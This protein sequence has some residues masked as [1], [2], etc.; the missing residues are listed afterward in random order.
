MAI[1]AQYNINGYNLFQALNILPTRDLTTADSFE[2]PAGTLEPDKYQWA[3]GILE[4][5]LLA[6][7]I[8]KPRTPTIK[9]IVYCDNISIYNS[10][11]I[12]LPGFLYQP[13]VTLEAV[14]LGVK[15]NARL[16][17]DGISWHRITNLT[18]K[19]AVEVQF[20]FDEILQPVPYKTDGEFFFNVD[21]NMDLLVTKDDKSTYTFALNSRKQLILTKQ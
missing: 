5:D 13:Y 10:T 1:T 2:K 4:Y 16:Q 12:A 3:E 17:P 6:P 14:H 18:S 19:I 15:M 20:T 7:V 11:K 9:G 21:A 8:Q